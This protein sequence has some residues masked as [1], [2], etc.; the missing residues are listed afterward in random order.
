M[1]AIATNLLWP[2][3][4]HTVAYQL[5]NNYVL[6]HKVWHLSVPAQRGTGHARL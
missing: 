4:L 5:A 1:I 2:D 6:H 3:P